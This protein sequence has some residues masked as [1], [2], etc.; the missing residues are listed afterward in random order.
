[1]LANHFWK[2]VKGRHIRTININTFYCIKEKKSKINTRVRNQLNFKQK[3]QTTLMHTF[4]LLTSHIKRKSCCSTRNNSQ[5][6]FVTTVL[7]RGKSCKIDS[8]KVAPTPRLHNVAGICNE[9]T[10]KK[11]YINK[12]IRKWVEIICLIQIQSIN[13]NYVHISLCVANGNTV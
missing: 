9:Q 1:M 8:P 12:N 3:P 2:R 6:V 4:W 5:V 11:I 10:R 13:S 7:S